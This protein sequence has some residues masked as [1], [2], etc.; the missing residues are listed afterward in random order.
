M[1]FR[2]IFEEDRTFLSNRKN[3]LFHTTSPKYFIQNADDIGSILQQKVNDLYIEGKTAIFLSG[4]M[5]SA[6][7]ASYLPEGTKAYTFECI[8]DKSID[9]TAQAKNMLINTD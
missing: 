3:H 1:A 5:D 4:G 9:E 7:I 2:T 8:A 6:N